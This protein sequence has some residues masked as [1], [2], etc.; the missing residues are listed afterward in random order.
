M[1]AFDRLSE[2]HANLY[3]A[4]AVLRTWGPTGTN[5]NDAFAK[6]VADAIREASDIAESLPELLCSARLD[7]QIEYVEMLRQ[8]RKG[9]RQQEFKLWRLWEKIHSEIEQRNNADSASAI[10]MVQREILHKILGFVQ[11]ELENSK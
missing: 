6:S 7:E 2:A 5:P 1:S 3:A 10:N 9:E 4:V 11:T 8:A